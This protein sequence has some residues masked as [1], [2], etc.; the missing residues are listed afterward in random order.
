MMNARLADGQSV[1]GWKVAGGTTSSLKLCGLAAVMTT[2]QFPL[3]WDRPCSTG[4]TDSLRK[5]TKKGPRESNPNDLTAEAWAPGNLCFYEMWLHFIII[6][7]KVIAD[8]YVFDFINMLSLPG[9]KV[10]LTV[11]IHESILFYVCWTVHRIISL[12]NIWCNDH[13][14]LQVRMLEYWYT[15]TL[16]NETIP[17]M[18]L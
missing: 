15:A 18:A 12:Q 16:I 17:L 11:I 2:T 13:L 9:I 6:I 8:V 5:T 10:L 3:W 1:R 4:A 7:F 14:S